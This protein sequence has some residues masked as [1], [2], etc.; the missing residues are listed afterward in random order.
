MAILT[1][2][3]ILLVTTAPGESKAL[4]RVI[5]Q[6]T[7]QKTISCPI[8][9]RT[10][11]YL[12]KING[13]QVFLTRCQQGSGGT[14]GSQET[15]QIAISNLHPKA[16]IM[17]GFAF[18]L[19]PERQNI[20][21][22]LVSKQLSLYDFQRVGTSTNAEQQIRYRGDRPSASAGLVDW[23]D[24]AALLGWDDNNGRVQSGIVLTG[25]K[26]VD[27]LDF[28]QHLL[29]CEPEAIGGEMEGAGLY[30]ACHD[31]K[32]D[33]ILVK[34]ICDWADKK[35][36]N[37][38]ANQTKAAENAAN[39]VL[40]AI[41]HSALPINRV[42]DTTSRMSSVAYE[43]A[44]KCYRKLA[45]ESC[46][47]VNLSNLPE[48]DR[49]MATRLLSLR[50]LYVPLHVNVE[51]SAGEDSIQAGLDA[52]ES[53]RLISQERASWAKDDEVDDTSTRFTIGERLDRSKRI[54]VLGD[55][56]AGKTTLTRWLATAYLLRLNE[57]PDW[58]D[59]PDV[60]SLPDN[61]WLPIIIRCR[62]LDSSI[63]SITLP[64]ILE[65]TFRKAEMESN[66]VQ[67]LHQ[68]IR[69][70]LQSGQ[71]ILMIDGLDE[72][73]NPSLRTKFCQQIE[74]ICVANPDAPIIVTSRIVGYREM[75]YRL[76]RGFEH[77]TIA[78]FS[79]DDKDDFAHR[80]CEMTKLPEDQISSAN[81]LIK[82]IHSS[83]RIERLTRNPMLL[84]TMALVKR[85][86]GRLPRKRF[87]LYTGAMDVLL[88]WRR[89][90]DTPID[91]SEVIPQLEYIA[92]AMCD[93][94]V[95]Q[96]REDE[97]IGL[98][99][100]MR[101]E[102]PQIHPIKNNSSEDF[103]KIIERKTGILMQTGVRRHKGREVPVF[104]FR[105]LTF[106]EYLAGI[107][108]VD[109]RYPNRDRSKSLADCVAILT[110]QTTEVKDNEGGVEVAIIE[111]WREALRLGVSS[112]SDDDIDAVIRA[113]QLPTP[114]EEVAIT[115]KPRLILASQCLADE[116]NVHDSVAY[117]I[118]DE[119]VNK[120]DSNDTPYNSMAVTIE[121]LASSQ[122]CD[123]LQSRLV[124]R[125]L[126]SEGE[127]LTIL[128]RL[129]GAVGGGSASKGI[130]E[131]DT[132][133]TKQIGQIESVNDIITV[134]SVLAISH[135]AFED[136]IGKNVSHPELVQAL[137]RLLY[138]NIPV[139]FAAAWTLNTLNSVSPRSD[140]WRPSEQNLT[141]ILGILSAP[142]T[143][144]WV[145]IPLMV[146]LANER[147]IPALSEFCSRLTSECEE[148]R[149]WA[150]RGIAVFGSSEAVTPLLSTLED[151][152]KRVQFSVL[153]A[154]A[155][156]P[157]A[158]SVEPLK[159]KLYSDEMRISIRAAYALAC[160][161]TNI[162]IES[163][164]TELNSH[165]F[166]IR[167]R[168]VQAIGVF[169]NSK[170]TPSIISLLTDKYEF[171][172]SRAA[173][174]L[175]RIGDVC[176]VKPLIRSLQDLDDLVRE[177]S[178]DALGLIA[179]AEAIAPLTVAL[180]DSSPT[181]QKACKNALYQIALK[182]FNTGDIKK[183]TEVFSSILTSLESDTGRNNLAF[184]KILLNDL[185]EA[186]EQ[187]K[188][189]RFSRSDQDWPLFQHNR[190][191]LCFLNKNTDEGVKRIEEALVW[192]TEAR[193]KKHH[194]PTADNMLLL[195]SK[196]ITWQKDI[197]IAV[198]CIV[199]LHR[200]RKSNIE[201]ARLQLLEYSSK[202]DEW[203]YLL[204]Q[205]M[206]IV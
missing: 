155:E 39:F 70:K 129:C 117:E 158:R 56:G 130:S 160:I 183:A 43:E 69:E 64:E 152:S 50:K 84:T 1:Q 29:L 22:I 166:K 107:A 171:V 128:A 65:C 27:N 174:A 77:V 40:H 200:M 176:A 144:P 201:E 140:A 26:L 91:R 114:Q 20:G 172:R 15:I 53:K 96:L 94:G 92:Y 125:F 124:E 11:Q 33:W 41:E 3:D 18:G 159:K 127:L 195:N 25:D 38:E 116:P 83:D 164:E 72:I 186:H 178:A 2:A 142:G 45:L 93:R 97:I 78:D 167:G 9:G 37:K 32:V 57:D 123:A 184:C 136:R 46:D 23:L 4:L 170:W 14:G 133:F 113:I 191:I 168:M 95:Q 151:T 82:D 63:N 99:D 52:M 196:G 156:L 165:D 111:S 137:F 132:W 194:I 190:G 19:H 206:G 119:L 145:S 47:I 135:L 205:D 62:D 28:R 153:M 115:A 175:G 34:A 90:I 148:V 112:C 150:V 102:Y 122:W 126:T 180:Q 192:L 177:K 98:L 81:E 131:L 141:E 139:S 76:G 21:D 162:A 182:I 185:D 173:D 143:N 120:I 181:V 100:Q 36:D 108:L 12:G 55:P 85:K 5:E 109:G 89:E 110:S 67:A 149:I 66:Q 59:M 31:A 42:Q 199:N 71:A 147:Y 30:V 68:V 35:A 49:N 154:L 17:L 73:T 7:G 88:N 86:I 58:N 6:K 61:D 179:D 101:I 79:A 10:Y 105:H 87:E 104:E 103:L 118:L 163:L 187:F 134:T 44:E 13:S 8:G 54:V 157:D 74:Q 146:I 197:P 203:S 106:Q 121:E 202:P 75:G 161:D 80:W 193:R 51:G 16:V 48:D 24:S 204:S 188:A 198:A 60:T 169:G 189:M 138:K